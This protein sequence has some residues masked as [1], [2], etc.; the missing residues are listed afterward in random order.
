MRYKK[1]AVHSTL[2]GFLKDFEA[3]S[4][5]IKGLLATGDFE[6]GPCLTMKAGDG[7]PVLYFED[8]RDRYAAAG[9]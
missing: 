1:A 2:W 3:E 5:R 6:F 4:A 8:Y 9:S 7:K